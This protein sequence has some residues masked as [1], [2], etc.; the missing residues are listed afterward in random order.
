MS[1]L[2][3]FVLHRGSGLA[4][5][6]DVAHRPPLHPLFQRFE[7]AVLAAA[8]VHHRSRDDHRRRLVP[9]ARLSIIDAHRNPWNKASLVHAAEVPQQSSPVP[10]Q[11]GV[12]CL[13]DA[14]K[15]PCDRGW[16]R[17]VDLASR[18]RCR[19]CRS[20]TSTSAER[21]NGRLSGGE[22]RQD[23]I[24]QAGYDVR[25]SDGANRVV[26]S[27]GGSIAVAGR[28]PGL[29]RPASAR[30]PGGARHRGGDP[31]DQLAT[32]ARSL[33]RRGLQVAQSGRP[34]VVPAQGLAA[35]RNT[36]GQARA[37]FPCSRSDRGSLHLLAQSSPEPRRGAARNRNALRGENFRRMTDC[38]NIQATGE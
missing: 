30:V 10:Y 9:A 17:G 20:E 2:A 15:T 38:R 36:I 18:A 23:L 34:P 29:R 28:R 27:W 19:I 14:W 6:A 21:H 35:R 31:L 33:R 12:A 22:R 24:R 13:D 26:R 8:G 5:V 37:Q 32:R 16:E 7:G 11:I 25:D 4:G 3:E 1:P